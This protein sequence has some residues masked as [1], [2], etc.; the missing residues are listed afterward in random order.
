MTHQ[1]NSTLI[2]SCGSDHCSNADP[3][4]NSD[5]EEID[6]SVC[7]TVVSVC[8]QIEYNQLIMFLKILM[9]S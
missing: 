7:I 4:G 6:A 2:Q 3:S 9:A 5:P 1:N 8:L